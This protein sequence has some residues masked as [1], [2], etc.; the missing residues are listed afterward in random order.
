[1]PELK[2]RQTSK[3]ISEA[4]AWFAAGKGT[5]KALTAERA[6]LVYAS[7]E[8]ILW[9]TPSLNKLYWRLIGHDDHGRVAL[10]LDST[11]GAIGLEYE[12]D[13]IEFA[14]RHER[15]FPC[16]YVSSSPPTPVYDA[17]PPNAPMQCTQASLSPPCTNPA[18]AESLSSRTLVPAVVDYWHD[19]SSICNQMINSNQTPGLWPFT[20]SASFPNRCQVGPVSAGAPSGSSP[21]DL[22]VVVA[23]AYGSVVDQCSG[24]PCWNRGTLFFQEQTVTQS[25]VG[26]EWG[27][28]TLKNV[29]RFVHDSFP[30]SMP[31]AV[32][33]FYCMP[34]GSASS[35]PMN[36]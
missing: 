28:E 7:A 8:W 36:Q 20:P 35:Q 25:L 27:H 31:N 32:T 24:L 19:R 11:S 14:P 17:T 16:D 9:R 34:M 23:H 15:H 22:R 33:E 29:G 6:D 13:K 30:P 10:L 26:H 1:M 4:E 5:G 18:Y 12:P 2:G 3:P 21:P